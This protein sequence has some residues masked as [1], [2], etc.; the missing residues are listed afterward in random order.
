MAEYTDHGF[1]WGA[2]WL[3]GILSSVALDQNDLPRSLQLR[4]ASLRTFWEHGDLA[5]VGSVLLDI[6]LLATRLG[7]PDAA[8]RFLGIS[9]RIEE[10]TGMLITGASF[11]DETTRAETLATLGPDAFA[12][13]QA[14]GRSLPTSTGVAAA[15][16]LTP[17]KPATPSRDEPPSNGKKSAFGLTPRELEILR[18]LIS[19]RTTN[20]DLADILSISPKTAGNHVDNIMAKMGV[21]SRVAAVALATRDGLIADHP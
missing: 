12:A 11:Q 15:L 8:A 20:R 9:S 4:Q 7:Q 16:T 5:S 14:E 19:G 21:N 1:D 13:G 2:A 18:V 6:A 10:A 17:T 3:Q